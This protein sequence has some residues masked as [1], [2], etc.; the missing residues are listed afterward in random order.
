MPH[1]MNHSFNSFLALLLCI[2]CAGCDRCRGTE[3]I[4]P[5]TCTK[6]VDYERHSV[7]IS[8]IS[9]TLPNLDATLGEAKIIPVQRDATDE[10]QQMDLQLYSICSTLKSLSP[11]PGKDKLKEEYVRLLM[12]L[13]EKSVEARLSENTIDSRE[14]IVPTIHPDLQTRIDQTEL[15]KN[16]NFLTTERCYEVFKSADYKTLNLFELIKSISGEI[17]STTRAEIERLRQIKESSS[18]CEI[19][20]NEGGFSA[21]MIVDINKSIKD[22]FSDKKKLFLCKVDV[23]SEFG[24]GYYHNSITLNFHSDHKSLEELYNRLTS[25]SFFT[26]AQEPYW[27]TNT[28]DRFDKVI[29]FYSYEIG[30]IGTNYLGRGHI[31]METISDAT[32]TPKKIINTSTPTS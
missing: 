12:R 17:S 26:R 10:L 19:E 6:F 15:A 2:I 25:S 20:E 4:L 28:S 7:N 29:K 31:K 14:G 11:G 5:E 24:Q 1:Y 32:V 23:S 8:G 9:A 3:F 16:N 27:I 18:I 13:Y 21:M 30:E 22:A